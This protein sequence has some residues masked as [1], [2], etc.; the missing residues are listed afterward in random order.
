MLASRVACL[1]RLIH[2]PRGYSGP[3]SRHLLAYHSMV[4]A[5]QASMRDMLEICLVT[6]FLEGGVNR[7]R[8]DWMEIALMYC[9]Q[10]SGTELYRWSLL[11]RVRLPLFD[12]DSC[13][14]GVIILHY[15][16]ELFV[17]EDPTSETT[18]EEMTSRGQGWVIHSDFKASQQLAY[19]LWDA[20]SGYL[21]KDAAVI[22]S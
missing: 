20:V 11:I 15:L 6:M 16:D 19:Q 5:V 2:Q 3:L 13:A 12:E 22:L 21:I 14:L 4:S 18:R 7:E 9:W 1:G 10:S 8:E 17:R